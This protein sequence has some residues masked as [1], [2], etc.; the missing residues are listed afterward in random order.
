MLCTH[1]RARAPVTKNRPGV[2]KI[3]PANFFVS[4]NQRA[5]SHLAKKGATRR[6][7]TD[8][9]GITADG[10]WIRFADAR[11]FA[12]F[13]CCHLY[14]ITTSDL[15]LTYVLA[16]MRAAAGRLT[17]ATQWHELAPAPVG[18]GRRLLIAVSSQF[19]CDWCDQI[20]TCKLT[21]THTHTH[22]P[23]MTDNKLL[24]MEY[25]KSLVSAPRRVI[26]FGGSQSNAM[27]VKQPT[28]GPRT[29]YPPTHLP[30]ERRSPSET[31]KQT[32]KKTNKQT[33]CI[34]S[35]TPG[36]CAT[37]SQSPVGVCVLQPRDIV[38]C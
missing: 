30:T 27:L 2:Q 5:I 11:V 7:A 12:C 8:G 13:V 29:P 23:K 38:A 31:N 10:S 3:W 16:I 24:K 17:A 22:T 18:L 26:S 37:L 4:T 36:N 1:A 28:E 21:T 34:L 19:W 20:T 14:F 9:S 35:R 33:M 25:L 15:N 6:S 32:N